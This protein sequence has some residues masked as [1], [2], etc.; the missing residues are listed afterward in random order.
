MAAN[1]QHNKTVIGIV[2]ELE[3][4]RYIENI[5]DTS[6]MWIYRYGCRIGTLDIGFSIY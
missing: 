1:R 5:V 6:P 3:V 4:G 2:Y